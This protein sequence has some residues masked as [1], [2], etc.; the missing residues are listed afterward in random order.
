ML[1]LLFPEVKNYL[2]NLSYA[3]YYE[4]SVRDFFIIEA[5]LLIIR[6]VNI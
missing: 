1:L 2:H 4:G 6:K 5:L 3:C